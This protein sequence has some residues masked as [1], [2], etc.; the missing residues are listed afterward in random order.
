MIAYELSHLPHLD[1]H[2]FD[3]QPPAQGSTGAALGILVG[4]ISQKV[5][6][7]N[8]RLRETSIK[9]YASLIPELEKQLGRSLPGNHQGL[10]HLCFDPAD[11]TRWQSL[12]EIRQRQGYAL[13]IWT[14]AEVSDR[15]PD[16]R[17]DNLAAAIYSPSDRQV[18]PTALTLALVTAAQQRGV[19]FDFD[20]PVQG[21]T[22]EDG[23]CSC[24]ITP[25]RTHDADFVVIAAGLGSTPLT[26]NLHQ[27]V[28]IG[29]VLGQA[30][31]LHLDTPLNRP[32]WQPVVT[33]NDV[34]LVPLGG[35]DYWVGATVEFPPDINCQDFLTIKPQ[36]ERL[37]E[38]LQGAIA[39]CPKLAAATISDL[40]FGLRPRPQ[41]QAAP[42][43]GPLA[44]YGN[45]WLACGHYRNGVLLAPATALAVVEQ[46]RKS[47]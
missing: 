1:I 20:S 11:L 23:L 36:A 13:E 7:R 31:R 8:W 12:R 21:L 5:K 38:V 32:D 42:V 46:L 6:G 19:R 3:Q 34:H 15:C 33:G 18:D 17:T 14:P 9:R 45:V 44:G 27:P 30:V 10:L 35:G 47:C 41:G 28:P 40:W 2:V 24:L 37:E 16:L 25:H 29:P 43:L 26:Q 22:A 4:V 39:Y